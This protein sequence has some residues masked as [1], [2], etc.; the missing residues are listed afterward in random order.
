MKINIVDLV[1]AYL[2]DEEE[3][4]IASKFYLPNLYMNF[5]MKSKSEVRRLIDGG[6]FYI[7]NKRVNDFTA[8]LSHGDMVRLGKKQPRKI[9]MPIIEM[10]EC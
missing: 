3:F 7:N 6:G 9:K 4:E 10:V 8:V 5:G 2:S 1:V